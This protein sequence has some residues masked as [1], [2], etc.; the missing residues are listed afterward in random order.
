M[1]GYDAITCA[2]N[3]IIILGFVYE[4]GKIMIGGSTENSGTVVVISLQK[5]VGHNNLSWV[6]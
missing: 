2:Y 4:R 1:C 6:F 5:P 3:N